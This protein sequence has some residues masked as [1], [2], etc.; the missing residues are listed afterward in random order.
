[1]V[2]PCAVAMFK[3]VEGEVRI[4][5]LAV[6]LKENTGERAIKEERIVKVWR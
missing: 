2:E 1:M 3:Q 6:V 4:E 5:R